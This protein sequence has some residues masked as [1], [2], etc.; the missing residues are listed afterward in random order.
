M[1][2]IGFEWSEA[3]DDDGRSQKFV[4]LERRECVVVVMMMSIVNSK[5]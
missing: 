5:Q 2:W 3:D 4:S 1:E